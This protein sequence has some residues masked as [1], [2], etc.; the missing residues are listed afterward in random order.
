MFILPCVPHPQRPSSTQVI[1]PHQRYSHPHNRILPSQ[2]FSFAMK[3]P[4]EVE[5][6][7]ML[8]ILEQSLKNDL[9]R[10]HHRY[11]HLV[12]IKSC[13]PDHACPGG[14]NPPSTQKE[15][16]EMD[17]QLGTV[18]FSCCVRMSWPKVV[19]LKTLKFSL[20]ERMIR[21]D[22]HMCR[23]PE[24]LV[25]E[26]CSMDNSINCALRH[27]ELQDWRSSGSITI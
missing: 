24:S 4:A 5:D 27:Q 13:W 14:G 26:G 12:Q 6:R 1:F 20:V 7:F 18:E 9:A 23:I 3:L 16:A 8:A 10:G 11:Q 15:S 22:P 17:E 19:W 25:S 2:K 21:L